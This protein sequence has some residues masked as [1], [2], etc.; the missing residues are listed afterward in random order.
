[1]GR[2]VLYVAFLP[3]HICAISE[4]KEV[5]APHFWKQLVISE[6]V[7]IL[8]LMFLFFLQV[9]TFSFVTKGLVLNSN[10]SSLRI[11]SATAFWKRI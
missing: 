7:R 9:S 6:Q 5:L 2:D 8:N 1:M 11:A 3:L 10:N 4:R